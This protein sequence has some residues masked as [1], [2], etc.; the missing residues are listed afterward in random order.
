VKKDDENND[1]EKGETQEEDG[2]DIEANDDYLDADVEEKREI[3]QTDVKHKTKYIDDTLTA[4]R[5]IFNHPS[6]P[7][8]FRLRYGRARN[9]GHAAGGVSP[10]TM[11]LIHNYIGPGTQLKT[12]RPGKAIAAAPVESL[13]GPT[14]RL[15]NGE[16]FRIDTED[17]AEKYRDQI[18]EILDL[19]EMGMPY[20]EFL[21]NN[22]KLVPSSYV[23][24]W[25][26]QEAEKAGLQI[27][28]I[29]PERLNAAQVWNMARKYEIP[30]HPKY[31]YTWHDLTLDEYDE[32][33]Q[34]IK[35][36]TEHE[37]GTLTVDEKATTHLGNLLTPHTHDKENQ[38]VTLD[39]DHSLTIQNCTSTTATQ[40]A[41]HVMQAVNN[42]SPVRIREKAPIRIGT[43]MGR[44]EKAEERTFQRDLDIHALYPVGTE[45]DRKIPE[46]ARTD[47]TQNKTLTKQRKKKTD[48]DE[49]TGGEVPLQLS[50][51]HCKD[52][53]EDTHRVKCQKC[54]SRTQSQA[55]C[56]KCNNTYSLT[57]E[58]MG[59]KECPECGEL[60]KANK[61]QP[62]N[63]KKRLNEAYE[64]L[65]EREG[66]F[67]DFK[68]V[69]G[70]VSQEKI[71]EPLEKGVLRAKHNVSVYKDGTSRYDATNLPLTSFK[72]KNVGASI[73]K[74]NQ[75]GYDTDINGNPLENP[76]QL[77]ELKIQDVIVPRN[78]EEY[79][80][81]VANYIDE[82]LENYYGVQAHYNAQKPE[83]LIGNLIIGMA[84]H[85]SAGALGRIIGFTDAHAQYA[86]PFYHAAKR[87]NCFHP[88]EKLYYQVNDEWKYGTIQELVENHIDED[89]LETDD[90]GSEYSDPTKTIKVPSLDDQGNQT[91]KPLNKVQRNPAPNHMITFETST[92]REITVTPDH[93]M[94]VYENSE[95]KKIPARDVS[96]G[97]K[98]LEP[99][100]LDTINGKTNQ[101]FDLLKELTNAENV[102]N[103]KLTI[104]NLSE[105]T[106]KQLYETA[107]NVNTNGNYLAE[108]RD[109]LDKSKK[110]ISNYVYRGNI[111]VSFLLQGFET[112][113]QLCKAVPDNAELGWKRNPITANRH[114]ELDET[115]ATLLGYY[116]A[117]GFTRN[118]DGG[119]KVTTISA[120]IPE[121]R[122]FAQHAFKHA[123]GVEANEENH[124]KITASSAVVMHAM[125]EVFDAK[126]Y[127]H[128][129]VVP[130]C[131]MT[132][133]KNIIGHF[134]GGYTSG[135]GSIGSSLIVGSTV[136]QHLVEDVVNLLDRLGFDSTVTVEEPQ[137]LHTIFPD[138]Y[139]KG[140]KMS[141]PHYIIKVPT[142]QSEKFKELVNVDF[143]KKRNN[144]DKLSKK[145]R[146]PHPVEND[147]E[148][149]CIVEIEEVKTI[150]SEVDSTYNIEVRDTKKLVIGGIGVFQCDS[151]EDA[152][153]MALDG[154]L[155][156]SEHYLNHHKSGWSMDEPIVMSKRIDP[157]EIDDEAHNVDIEAQYPLEFYEATLEQVG[158]KDV[159]MQIAEDRLE[160]PVGFQHSLE[161]DKV[162]GGPEV[163]EYKTLPDMDAKIEAQFDISEKARAVDEADVAERV[164]DGHFIADLKGNLRAFG[165]QSV[166]CTS[167]HHNHRRPP[168]DGVCKRC[169][170]DSSWTINVHE[171]SV[172]KY[173]DN[174][175][176]MSENYEIS[177][178]IRQIIDEYDRACESL[179]EDDTD[180]QVGL[181]NFCD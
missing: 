109:R 177:P 20:G 31:T 66:S 142:T 23:H 65:T 72:P 158:P 96:E 29:N 151:D 130:E 69:E 133:D 129:K 168:L 7:G 59:E 89:N 153:M 106:V 149:M 117:E 171:G 98:F 53:N 172:T 181:G 166:R 67:E 68:G 70:L 54:G 1:S 62:H 52:C 163:T 146:N 21:E 120:S 78:S 14:V 39:T 49:L 175:K 173:L 9:T 85:T 111:P 58:E 24:E 26:E 48:E 4:G 13:E 92:G 16:V 10:A 160:N 135:D 136:S 148:D 44:P 105:E 115:L 139:Q 159:D 73:D 74:L 33:S 95:Q 113:N 30:L 165:E 83:D 64:T 75:L 87:R 138:S 55:S 114:V 116:T 179:F 60:N 82:L 17:E 84:P 76:D 119:V 91:L 25:W 5:P 137:D 15:H 176:V 6:E 71:P 107:F 2:E 93:G 178:Y 126:P 124:R 43:R 104:A 57:Q 28:G 141:K 134:I 3:V 170:D 157:T 94:L 131:I 86:H 80:L 145:S 36:G 164:I 154:L 100:H 47:N 27:S 112:T 140:E 40:N 156:Y 162:D 150:E 161:S 121:I 19:G 110:T 127:A 88:D 118:Q 147:C 180:K 51:R 34:L 128:E 81:S 37:D 125:K 102:D 63:I 32:L 103:Q 38:T 41:E 77:C 108:L 123:F 18:D 46:A 155:N 143:S 56:T 8:G 132:A 35:N 167:C 144:L 101:T 12:E 99:K 45:T 79:L 22:A 97:D 90:Y 50:T 152:F 42:A 61:R 169:G 11:V 174:M 122:D